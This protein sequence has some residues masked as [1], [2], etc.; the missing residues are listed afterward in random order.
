MYLSWQLYLDVCSTGLWRPCT[1]A[2]F[3]HGVFPGVGIWIS[4]LLYLWMGGSHTVILGVLPRSGSSRFARTRARTLTVVDRSEMPM[5]FPHSALSSFLNMVTIRASLRSEG[6]SSFPQTLRSRA[7]RWYSSS[8]PPSFFFVYSAIQVRNMETNSAI[9]V[10]H[11]TSTNSTA[12]SINIW[13]WWWNV[14][15][16]LKKTLTSQAM[17]H[18]HVLKYQKKCN[19]H[20]RVQRLSV[21]AN[22][23]KVKKTKQKCV[24]YIDTKQFTI[25]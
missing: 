8:G 5:Q 21:T 6:S 22:K 17:K 11:K 15:K 24:S 20:I 23:K 18:A 9:Q 7:W 14:T 4:C 16:Q 12:K 10:R 25:R 19:C 13:K 3:V 1:K 2:A